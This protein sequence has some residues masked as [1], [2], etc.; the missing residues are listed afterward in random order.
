MTRE[1]KLTMGK[2]AMVDDSDY[3]WINN[4]NK[5]QACKA[6]GIWY[7]RRDKFPRLM[8]RIIMGAKSNEEC[9]HINGNGLDNRRSN[10]RLSA[11]RQNMSNMKKPIGRHGKPTTSKYKGVTWY[12]KYNKWLAQICLNYKKYHQNI[13]CFHHVLLINLKEY[14]LLSFFTLL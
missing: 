9:D 3:E 2:K 12:K 1:I 6:P 4:M 13:L 11:H 5:W 8:H 14:F 10:L 7:A